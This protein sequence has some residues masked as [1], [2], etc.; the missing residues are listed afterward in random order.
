VAHHAQLFRLYACCNPIHPAL[1]CLAA[2][3]AELKP[4]PAEIER[5]D[6][7]TYRFASVMRNL[8]PPNYFA[9]KY[10]LPHAAAVMAVRGSAGFATL[11]DSALGDPTIA[12]LRHKVHIEE[13]P[14]MTALVPRLRP[15]KVTVTLAD[16]RSATHALESHRGDFNDPFGTDELRAKFRELAGVVVS[17]EGVA[18]IEA[19]VDRIEDWRDVGELTGL[20]RRYGRA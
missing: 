20:L 8:D 11:D 1:D 9:S 14:A 10:S 18:A 2:A 3:L 4:T 6:V 13:D 15:A 16:G 5:I 12:A 19:A 7:A 17:G